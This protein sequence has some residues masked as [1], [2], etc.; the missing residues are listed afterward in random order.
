MKKYSL[1]I[2]LSLFTLLA[3]AQTTIAGS[4]TITD[5][6]I[7]SNATELKWFADLVNGKLTNGEAQNRN[8]CAELTANIDLTSVCSSTTDSWTP[9]GFDDA[10]AYKGT[11]DGKGFTVSNI[12]IDT[13]DTKRN[14]L[15][16]TTEGA[17][18]KNIK[19]NGGTIAGF[20]RCAALIGSA[21]DGSVITGIVIKDFT[22]TG[23]NS[24][25]AI[26]GGAENSTI[27]NC[28]VANASID[29][30]TYVGGLCGY[31]EASNVS[32][33]ALNDISITS[34]SSYIGGMI[35]DMKN[36]SAVARC[37][38]NGNVKGTYYVG[39]FVGYFE[40]STIDCSMTSASV[41]SVQ[42][43]SSKANT[44]GFA[45]Y[46]KLGAISNSFTVSPSITGV[47][48]VSQ[49]N[50][51][52][53]AGFCSADVKYCAYLADTE[54]KNN[55]ATISQGIASMEGLGNA[56]ALTSNEYANGKAT[57]LL[58]GNVSGGELWK[59][60]LLNDKLPVLN[61]T[62]KVYA[63]GTLNCDGSA[64]STTS[65]TNTSSAVATASAHSEEYTTIGVCSHCNSLNTSLIATDANGIYQISNAKE[66]QWF[67]KIVNTGT[68]K[69]AKGVLT[70]DIDLTEVCG[71]SLGNWEPIG[72]NSSSAI[73]FRGSFDGQGHTIKG[74]YIKTSTAY[75]GLFG[76]ADNAVIKNFTISA[77]SVTGANNAAL[78]IG[79]ATGST[80][81]GISTTSDASIVANIRTAGI[82]GY[83]YSGTNVSDCHNAAAV[84][85][86]NNEGAGISGYVYGNGITFTNCSNSGIIT[87]EKGEK[88]GGVLG[89][90]ASTAQNGI[91]I[92]RC[93]NTADI[94]A[95]GGI[96]GASDLLVMGV[97][98][99]TINQNLHIINNCANTGNVSCA[100]NY[101]GGIA[102]YAT[103]VNIENCYNTGE[104]ISSNAKYIGAVAGYAVSSVNVTNSYYD[105]TALASLKLIGNGG[106]VD[107]AS[108]AMTTE[109]FAS[110]EVC[111]LLNAGDDIVWYQTLK[112]DA[113]PMLDNTHKR[114]YYIKDVYCN[115]QVGDVNLDGE[116]NISDVTTLV[117]IILGKTTDVNGNANVNGDND[118]NISDVTSLVNIILGK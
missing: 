16:G 39:G 55:S 62:D 78:A 26:V 47:S 56:E 21:L 92:T 82:V 111:Y 109:A 65:F 57:Y 54:A 84:T 5:P 23:E 75:Q 40:N 61:G 51:G 87:A 11:F 10:N 37:S 38:I 30:N 42:T 104:I 105:G 71:E 85:C 52:K 44:G 15:F 36:K 22:I 45:G 3:T 83:T 63:S 35:G 90:I 27:S 31:M 101:M 34:T 106:K 113:T 4:G 98:G 58:N 43:G 29:A 17:T 20:R 81:S 19:M 102:G 50:I 8:A 116:V 73:V 76:S 59:Q 14:G 53:F 66:L 1:L 89:G 70:A 107:T 32:D 49:P 9:I 48:S 13:P 118:I 69:F 95:Q 28:S 99:A 6:Y 79:Y 117:N 25:A 88:C 46:A 114:V 74:L 86:K 93:I 2:A 103:H 33:C 96:V 108:K 112:K 24:V 110:G 91:V 77:S 12:Y 97:N 100:H 72:N 67:A 64:L 7:I 115:A 41:A 60:T 68:D 80:I 18:V 94:T